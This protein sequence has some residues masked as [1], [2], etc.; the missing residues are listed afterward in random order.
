MIELNSL[1]S[2]KISGMLDSID[3]NLHQVQQKL[4]LYSDNT[5][6]ESLHLEQLGTLV[7]DF[8]T[9]LGLL[10][11]FWIRLLGIENLPTT[12][13]TTLGP[14]ADAVLLC[15]FTA[16]VYSATG[17]S[18]DAPKSPYPMGKYDPYTSKLYFQ[19]RLLESFGR[20]LKITTLSANFLINIA[21]D[22]AR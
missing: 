2:K 1:A 14:T 3:Q 17:G 15:L 19:N 21:L 16:A 13:P 18:I 7:S 10:D 9:N 22:A 6:V 11:E 5:L 8:K 12:I 20:A 4:A